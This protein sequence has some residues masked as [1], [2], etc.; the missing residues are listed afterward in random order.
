MKKNEKV[1]EDCKCDQFYQVKICRERGDD[2]AEFLQVN[3]RPYLRPVQKTKDH[4]PHT[5]RTVLHA[6][7]MLPD[8][9]YWLHW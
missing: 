7:L 4:Q 3:C 6:V 5:S 1:V 8:V 9:V 2:C